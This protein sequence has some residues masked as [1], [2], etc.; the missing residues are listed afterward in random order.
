MKYISPYM[1]LGLTV[2]SFSLVHLGSAKTCY[3]DFAAEDTEEINE[4]N[5]F[6]YESEDTSPPGMFRTYVQ[7]SVNSVFFHMFWLNP[8]GSQTPFHN[9]RIND[10]YSSNIFIWAIAQGRFLQ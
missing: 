7:K 8:D 5:D 1:Y 3:L 9:A 2:V 4:D 10:T 6:D